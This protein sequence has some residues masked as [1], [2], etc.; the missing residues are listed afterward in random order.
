ARGKLAVYPVA[1]CRGGTDF[2]RSKLLGHD[3]GWARSQRAIAKL[4]DGH[5]PPHTILG[6]CRDDR[7]VRLCHGRFVAAALQGMDH[8]WAPMGTFCRNDVGCG[9]YYGFLL[10]L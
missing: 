5:S 7:A 6:V 2:F 10:G 3:R 8:P 1:G 4:L 9:Y